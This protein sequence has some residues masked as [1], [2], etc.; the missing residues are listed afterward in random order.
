MLKIRED[1]SMGIGIGTGMEMNRSGKTHYEIKN[2]IDGSVVA[3]VTHTQPRKVTEAEKK[4]KRLQYDFKSI[5][6]MLLRAKT[7]V[8]ARRVVTKA[9]AKVAQL[10]RQLRCGEYDDEELKEAIIHAKKMERIAKKRMK[11]LQQEELAER[12]GILAE[13]MDEERMQT[14]DSQVLFAEDQ[15][16]DQ[17]QLQN[18]QE[19]AER[20]QEMREL[21]EEYQRLID[22]AMQEWDEEMELDEWSEELVG[23]AGKLDEEGLNRVKKKHRADELRDIMKADMQYLKA[24]FQ[25]LEREKQSLTSG[26]SR[27]MS[28]G[29]TG[30]MSAGTAAA[31]CGGVSLELSGMEAPIEAADVVAAGEMGESV[32]VTV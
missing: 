23:A 27:G 29:M 22:E 8:S 21:M 4:L 2:P 5:S 15:S 28:G 13:Q 17:E 12:Q 10:S 1:D 24:V 19:L 3:R 20:E 16:Q 9:R 31:P 25:R 32:D 26:I 30:G 14:E 7:S 11:N 18:E 6:S